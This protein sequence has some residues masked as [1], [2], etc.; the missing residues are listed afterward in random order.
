[1]V[2]SLPRYAIKDLGDRLRITI[3]S[4]KRNLVV[5]VV[6]LETGVG[7]LTECMIV[8]AL[9]LSITNRPGIEDVGWLG[10]LLIALVVVGLA[11]F[12][13]GISVLMW[14]LDG[15]E[16]IEVDSHGIVIRRQ[17]YGICRQRKYQV[18]FITNL[19]S[20]PVGYRD[21]MTPGFMKT[22]SVFFGQYGL[23]AF[24]YGKRGPQ[25]FGSGVDAF[26]ANQIVV[27]I[28]QKFPQ[29]VS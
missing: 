27:A 28:E 23:L 19:R 24:D 14:E 2:K 10:I 1:M 12:S 4:R 5:L 9:V 22:E 18:E 3:P 26:E 25:Y 29:Y 13:L 20:A 16:S 21:V 11:I 8:W 15:E 7:V 17:A 6:G